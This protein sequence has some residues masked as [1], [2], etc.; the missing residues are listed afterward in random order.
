MRQCA[1]LV[2]KRQ[3]ERCAF[4]HQ[5]PAALFI[6][7]VAESELFLAPSTETGREAVT[8]QSPI[9]STLSAAFSWRVLIIARGAQISIGLDDHELSTINP[10]LRHQ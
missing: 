6:Y 1:R 4:P 2:W 3:E 8:S 5:L 10:A 9:V 7:H